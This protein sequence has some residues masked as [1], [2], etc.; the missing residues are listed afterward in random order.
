MYKKL[1]KILLL[2]NLNNNINSMIHEEYNQFKYS[3]EKTNQIKITD[4][5]KELIEKFNMPIDNQT[6]EE[7]IGLLNTRLNNLIEEDFRI[8]LFSE[9][10]FINVFT[11]FSQY[12]YFSSDF[13]QFNLELF[14]KFYIK[15]QEKNFIEFKELNLVLNSNIEFK[16][17]LLI[18]SSL[19][20]NGIRNKYDHH[21]CTIIYNN[22]QESLEILDE[23]FSLLRKTKILDDIFFELKYQETIADPQSI[24]NN[25]KNITNATQIYERKDFESM[26]IIN[27]KNLL[28]DDYINHLIGLIKNYKEFQKEDFKNYTRQEYVEHLIKDIITNMQFEIYEM[29]KSQERKNEKIEYVYI[30]MNVNPQEDY[31][32]YERKLNEEILPIL[33]K[34]IEIKYKNLKEIKLYMNISNN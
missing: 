4:P 28:T 16:N 31:K 6:I 24:V 21:E 34:G 3:Q 18:E 30:Y 7:I 20:E 17:F 32:S 25:L 23:K 22:H 10:D 9:E 15:Y 8:G 26:H 2:V 12:R 33:M 19:I 11:M 5:L 29:C 1:I 14:Y 13:Y 27:R